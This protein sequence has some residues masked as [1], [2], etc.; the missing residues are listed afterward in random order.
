MAMGERQPVK[1]H[2]KAEARVMVDGSVVGGR[3]SLIRIVPR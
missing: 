1:R 3:H 2:K